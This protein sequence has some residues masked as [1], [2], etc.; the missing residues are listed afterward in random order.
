MPR[1]FPPNGA[2]TASLL[3]FRGGGACVSALRPWH[4]FALLDITRV[5]RMLIANM[6]NGGTLDYMWET[7]EKLRIIIICDGHPLQTKL[8]VEHISL[9]MTASGLSE[10]L[11]PLQQM[12]RDDE[13]PV[14]SYDG[15]PGAAA[16]DWRQTTDE[17]SVVRV[18]CGR[19]VRC[20]APAQPR[21]V[22]PLVGYHRRVCRYQC[23]PHP[24][25]ATA[26]HVMK[27]C[28]C[29][30]DDVAA[31]SGNKRGWGCRSYMHC[32]SRFGVLTSARL[33]SQVRRRPADYAGG[34]HGDA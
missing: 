14:E 33:P 1:R 26:K 6:R 20:E 25:A 22:A 9:M 16:A 23:V 12:I 34:G 3:T 13:V 8:R 2:R 18:G 30:I 28:S 7:T 15:R 21:G 19:S 31:V 5:R 17:W 11:G 24:C 4:R 32:C 27:R 10:I 29:V